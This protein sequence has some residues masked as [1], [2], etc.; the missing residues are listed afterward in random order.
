MLALF[1]ECMC[2]WEVAELNGSAK[3]LYW[4]HENKFIKDDLLTI[5]NELVVFIVPRVK[6]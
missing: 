2:V 5:T 6:P 3:I 4:A 1:I